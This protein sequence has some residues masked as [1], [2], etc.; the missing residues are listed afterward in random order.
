MIIR[1]EHNGEAPYSVISRNLLQENKIPYGPKCLLLRM[2]SYPDNWTFSVDSLS[3][4]TGEHP[5]TIR[6]WLDVLN[7]MGYFHKNVTMEFGGASITIDWLV[8]EYPIEVKH[9]C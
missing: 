6:E 7:T 9:G 5:T 3:E 4:A 2:L 1:A 8:S